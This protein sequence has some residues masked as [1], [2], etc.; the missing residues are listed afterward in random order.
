MENINDNHPDIS[1]NL[2][3]I[4]KSLFEVTTENFKNTVGKGESPEEALED[5][6]K[7]I[8]KQFEVISKEILITTL[9]K[10]EVMKKYKNFLN[11]ENKEEKRLFKKKNIFK[12]I[13]KYITSKFSSKKRIN[14]IDIHLQNKPSMESLLTKI[15]ENISQKKQNANNLRNNLQNMT[16][17]MPN[18]P[19]FVFHD[20]SFL[21]NPN[22]YYKDYK[23]LPIQLY[24][25]N[26]GNVLDED[27]PY[28]II[29][30]LN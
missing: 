21:L 19:Y 18:N 16:G 15:N 13:T 9:Y 28:D 30:N 3:K 26:E 1:F 6:L 22:P 24:L 4:S 2:K 27:F 8:S 7:R 5:L 14:S 25:D 20:E 17:K 23:G 11:K 12:K 10:K 29:V